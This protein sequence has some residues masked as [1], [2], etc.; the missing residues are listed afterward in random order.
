MKKHKSGC[1]DEKIALVLQG[2]G[3]LFLRTNES[4][5]LDLPVDKN[6]KQDKLPERSVIFFTNIY[7]S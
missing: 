1:D 2:H 3:Y 6:D 7:D 5:R 4:L